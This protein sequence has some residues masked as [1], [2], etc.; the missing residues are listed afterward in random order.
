MAL[1][2]VEL[3]ERRLENPEALPGYERVIPELVVR[4][5]FVPA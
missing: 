5:S 2:A 3:L 4:K 1:R